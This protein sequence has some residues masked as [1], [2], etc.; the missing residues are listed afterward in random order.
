M[1][2]RP[3]LLALVIV[4]ISFAI[5]LKA[6]DWLS[7]QATV[8]AP[9]LAQ[10]PPL[11]QTTRRSTILAPIAI[12]LGAIRDAA[13]RGTPRNFSGKANNPVSQIL[14][15]ADIGWTASRGSITAAGAQDMLTLTTPLTGTLH[16]MGSLSA[17]ATGALGNALGGLLGDNVAKQV[18]SV[19]IKNVNANADIKGNV[20]LTARPKITTDWHVDPNLNGQ[21][22]LGDSSLMVAGARLSVP[23]QVKP[24]IDKA[25]ADQIA[26][27]QARL[28]NDPT[29]ERAARQQWTKACRSIP[30]PGAGG[31]SS[32]PLWLEL[33][34]LRALAAQPT[35]DSAN[36]TLTLGIE[37]ETRVTPAE[38][39]P[40][41]PFPATIEIVPPTPGRVAIGVPVDM[42]FTE[43]NKIIEAQFAGKTFPED[44][45]GP[46]DVTVKRASVAASGDRLLISLLVN[47]KEKKSYFGLGGEANVH[48]WGRPVLD[49]AQQTLRLT[50]IQLAVES[51][52]AFGLLG[53][54]AR[55]AMPQLQK[56]L[57]EK[58]TIDLKPFASNAQKKIAAVIADLQ[59]NENGVRVSA[60]ISKLRLAD[61]A[62]D[63]KTLRVIA[64][65][66]G[67]INVYVTAL[68]AL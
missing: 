18:G 52:A 6:M 32:P 23:A 9:V 1:K 13:E 22:N 17:K 68:P 3:V 65:A 35:L 39:K 43:I 11:P 27:V 19:N 33:R 36:M 53:A 47:A 48:I 34:P 4:A 20:V 31:A 44:G 66:E 62:F 56:A 49:Q 50:D 41:C 42:P 10:L 60:E 25:V 26:N 5:S 61:I 51:E 15:N 7:Q 12:S 58:A 29:L 59:K 37:A 57:A 40:S 45:S 67:A 54:A 28:R 64:E 2:I 38:T 24:V 8:K 21:V 55:A 46:A 63:S 14:E 30:L 16:V